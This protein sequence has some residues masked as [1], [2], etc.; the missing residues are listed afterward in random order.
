MDIS[1]SPGPDDRGF[2]FMG[3]V[4]A[5]NSSFLVTP[6]RPSTTLGFCAHQ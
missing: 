5:A 3:S 1:P 4:T 2:P 6:I